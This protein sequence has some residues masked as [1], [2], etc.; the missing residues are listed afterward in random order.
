M[1][2]SRQPLCLASLGVALISI[3]VMM[4][5]LLLDPTRRALDERCLPRTNNESAMIALWPISLA[6]AIGQRSRC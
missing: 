2:S 6:F 1:R 3:Y 5:A 4:G